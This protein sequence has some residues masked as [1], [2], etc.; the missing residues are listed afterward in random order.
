MARTSKFVFLLIASNVWLT[1]YLFFYWRIGFLL[2]LYHS[3]PVHDMSSSGSSLI[4]IVFCI[5]SRDQSLLAPHKTILA[6]APLDKVHSH[7]S[8]VL[9]LHVC[10]RH[11]QQRRKRTKN[12]HAQ[13]PLWQANRT[14]SALVLYWAKH[15]AKIPPLWTTLSASYLAFKYWRKPRLVLLSSTA[16]TLF[17]LK[18]LWWQRIC[19]IVAVYGQIQTFTLRHQPL[20]SLNIS[21][22]ACFLLVNWGLFQVP[23]ILCIFCVSIL[24]H[25]TFF[26]DNEDTCCSSGLK[27][28]LRYLTKWF[29]HTSPRTFTYGPPKLFRCKPLSWNFGPEIKFCE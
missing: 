19:K 13:P 6:N 29:L 26:S 7:S 23:E 12:C 22:R 18:D 8:I 15:E 10:R 21:L 25:P 4:S 3:C 9:G 27:K 1:S 20:S 28:P 5:A 16:Q 24:E 2:V 11:T 17:F 14:W